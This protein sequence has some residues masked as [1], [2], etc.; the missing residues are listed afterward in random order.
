MIRASLLVLAALAGLLSPARAEDEKAG[1]A[2]PA[3]P[4][5]LEVGKAGAAFELKTADG[6]TVRLKD[7]L[8]AEGARAVVVE[9]AGA[10]CPFTRAAEKAVAGLLA[11]HGKKGL[12]VVSLF[13]NGA[14]ND[15][16]LREYAK[17][18]ESKRTM[19]GDPGGRV[20][21]AFGAEVTP[22]FFVF[23]APGVLRYRGAVSGLAAAVAA[24]LAGKPVERFDVPVVGCSIRPATKDDVAA[25]GQNA[26]PLSPEAE[27]WLDQLLG[28]L[29]T[30]DPAVARSVV[31]GI[32]A[33]GPGTLPHL[34]RW[35][36]GKTGLGAQRCDRIIREIRHPTDPSS[37]DGRRAI[38]RLTM[39]QMQL[40]ALEDLLDLTPEQRKQLRARF[41][42][43]RDEEDELRA[44]MQRGEREGIAERRKALVE[45]SQV[46]V[47]EILTEEQ[48][49]RWQKLRRNR[50]AGEGK[51]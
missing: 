8:A 10:N 39:L 16:V 33:M 14:D 23:D 42:D 44:D 5:P 48:W 37:R 4:A 12:A 38:T 32:Q 36:E 15:H 7:L 19:A 25:P 21:T 29:G 35:R 40:R 34:V 28:K 26:P 30:E 46:F 11:E 3:D 31:H 20:A 9:I 47:K 49:E 18:V 27:A 22:T 17:L 41:L 13:P 24:V 50:P 51:R 43:L 45:K 1:K 6:T 2:D